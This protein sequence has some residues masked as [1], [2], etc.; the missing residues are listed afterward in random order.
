MKLIIAVAVTLFI[1]P[2]LVAG[3]C[4]TTQDDDQFEVICNVTNSQEIATFFKNFD[5]SIEISK[6][7]IEGTIETLDGQNVFGRNTIIH[8]LKIWTSSLAKMDTNILSAN[9]RKKLWTLEVNLDSDEHKIE[10]R[11]DHRDIFKLI[12]LSNLKRA[13]VN[14][15]PDASLEPGLCRTRELQLLVLSSAANIGAIHLEA[16]YECVQLQQVIVRNVPI[17]KVIHHQQTSSSSPNFPK[18][19]I[20]FQNCSLHSSS[21]NITKPTIRNHEFN[22]SKFWEIFFI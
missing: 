20:Q 21:F 18:Q 14:V 1:L 8:R 17:D 22:F 10:S 15:L 19:Y 6:L 13:Y 7:T 3:T 16:F 12:N 9:N 5:S 2:A 11:L 4:S